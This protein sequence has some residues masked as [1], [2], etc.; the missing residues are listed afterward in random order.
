MV[1]LEMIITL[2]ELLNK[3]KLSGLTGSAVDLLLPL[4]QII[5]EKVV[6]AADVENDLRSA[7]GILGKN[8]VEILERDGKK[9]VV[10]KSF[11]EEFIGILK[12][13]L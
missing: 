12:E 11:G 3:S 6:K 8:N 10:A 9:V 7:G 1:F 4:H 2:F 5:N 13:F